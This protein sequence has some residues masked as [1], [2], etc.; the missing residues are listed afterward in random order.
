MDGHLLSLEQARERL[1]PFRRRYLGVVPIDV[2]SIIGTSDRAG[3]FDREF[4]ALRSNLQERQRRLARAFPNS[5]FAPVVVEKLGDA[6]FVI[7]GHHRVA[8]ARQRGMTSIDAE[9]TES[10]ARW[11]LSASAD[12]EELLHAE[13]ERLF[14]SESGLADVRA[15]ARVRFS[16]A[17]GYLQLLEAV[18]IHGYTLMLAAQRP[19]D[20]GEVAG[21]WYANVYRPAVELIAAAA[22]TTICAD[23]TESDAFL[24]L[25]QQRRELSVDHAG[26]Q[27]GDALQMSSG[28]ANRRRRRLRLSRR[29]R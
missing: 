1:R 29:R 19:L 4:T 24:W 16:R 22:P 12:A 13:Q 27:L 25:W 6:Y 10:T 3:D 23:A 21:D 20:R 18:Q 11:H 7:D 15:D 5:E 9:V 28:D 14:M 2:D 17:V 8:L 26:L